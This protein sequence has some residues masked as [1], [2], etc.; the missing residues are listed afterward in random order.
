MFNELKS[1]KLKYPI[2]IVHVVGMMVG[3]GVESVVM[4]YYRHID[5]DKI[6][7][8][9]IVDKNSTL[10]PKDEIKNLGGKIFITPLFRNL[11]C[12]KI[13][14]SNILKNNK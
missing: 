4:N 7:F 8:D 6:Q 11:I 2:H 1:N 10:I 9:F 3:G 14:L 12:S 13:D 5:R